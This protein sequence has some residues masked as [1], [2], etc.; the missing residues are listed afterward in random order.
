MAFSVKASPVNLAL[1]IWRINRGPSDLKTKEG[2][3]PTVLSAS[4]C[5][6][7]HLAWHEMYSYKATQAN[8]APD[9]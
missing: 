2:L 6:G 9:M 8:Q 3:F 1:E 4:V 7:S 5:S